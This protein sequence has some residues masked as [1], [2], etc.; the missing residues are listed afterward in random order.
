M[1]KFGVLF[2]SDNVN[3]IDMR[4]E[5]GLDAELSLLKI[6]LVRAGQN[7]RFRRKI[8]DIW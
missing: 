5:S 4:V 1:C 3:Y 6:G 8:H 2:Y 7:L